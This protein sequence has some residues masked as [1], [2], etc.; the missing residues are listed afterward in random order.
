MQANWWRS[1]V[2]IWIALTV[3]WWVAVVADIAYVKLTTRAPPLDALF[4]L[5]IVAVG[6]APPL[7]LL[8]A[9]YLANWVLKIFR[10]NNPPPR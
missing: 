3:I 2:R 6:L 9:G 1:F 8:A 10:R 4:V 7:L 5:V